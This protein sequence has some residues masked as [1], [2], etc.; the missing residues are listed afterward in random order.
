VKLQ[1]VP[2]GEA[3]ATLAALGEAEDQARA[4]IDQVDAQTRAA[5]T[6]VN[7]AREALV[8]LEA[9]SPTPGERK[10][11]EAR[12]AKAE[13]TVAERWPERRQGAERAAREAR[14]ALQLYA[15]EH[16]PEL[17]AEVEEE[18]RAVAEQV[19]HA[20]EAFLAAMKRRD[21]V[22]RNLTQVVA[23]TRSMQPNDYNRSVADDARRAI[24]ALLANGG[25][26]GPALRVAV[27]AA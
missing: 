19:D 18:G 12:L 7:E 3:M 1:L 5:H 27:T 15:A 13:Q 20:C 21:E 26:V 11:A 16:L 14:Q 4:R 2:I 22:E 17:V 6:E 8:Q 9:G 23:L 25:E 10:Q 24:R